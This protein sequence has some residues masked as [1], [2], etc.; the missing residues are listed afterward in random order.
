MATRLQTHLKGHIWR[1]LNMQPGSA[2]SGLSSSFGT[3]LVH[4]GAIW[5]CGGRGDCSIDWT[6]G[7]RP[8]RT[9]QTL[10]IGAR[11]TFRGQ[12]CGSWPVDQEL[13]APR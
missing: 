3:S 11:I 7:A 2:A 1:D 12:A 9:E 8:Q 4:V 6:E 13:Q 10:Q 5:P